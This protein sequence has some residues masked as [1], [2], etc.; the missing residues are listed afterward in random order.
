M[1]AKFMGTILLM[2]AN[3]CPG[4]KVGKKPSIQ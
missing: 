1:L 4:K 2:E 3:D